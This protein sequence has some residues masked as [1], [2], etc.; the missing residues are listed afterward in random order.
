MNKLQSG[1]RSLG[2]TASLVAVSAEELRLVAGGGRILD[3][4][5]GA[6]KW[7]YKH[8]YVD[9]KNRVIGGKGTF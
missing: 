1:N 5:K 2:D 3:A 7:V 8:V 6:A 9:V 4:I